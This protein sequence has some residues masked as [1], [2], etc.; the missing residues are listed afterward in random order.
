[1]AGIDRR[2]FLQRTT[3]ACLGAAALTLPATS[4]RALAAVAS[5]SQQPPQQAAGMFISLPPWAVARNT[6]WPE[7]ARIAARTGYAGID[8]PFGPVRAAGVEATRALL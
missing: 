6:G 5:A 7:Q 3:H 8:W 4:D 1:M 2:E